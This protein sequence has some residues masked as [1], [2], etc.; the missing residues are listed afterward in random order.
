MAVMQLNSQLCFSWIVNCV[1]QL[2]AY[3]NMVCDTGLENVPDLLWCF[4]LWVIN[5]CSN[6]ELLITC[7]LLCLY[8]YEK[9]KKEWQKNKREALRDFFFPLSNIYANVVISIWFKKYISTAK[10]VSSSS[11]IVYSTES[12]KGICEQIVYAQYSVG[13][14][15][16]S[17]E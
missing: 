15:I 9:Y 17:N 14:W 4:W 5:I 3:S 11:Y 2:K 16:Y 13:C 1:F 7:F 10:Q 8:M 6:T 12:N